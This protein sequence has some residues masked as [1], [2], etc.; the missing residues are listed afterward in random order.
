MAMGAGRLRIIRQLLVESLMLAGLGAALG[1]VLA[2]WGLDILKLIIPSDMPHLDQIGVDARV[3][4]FTL[5][6]SALTALI[7]GLVPA[8]EASHPDLNET[9]RGRQQ[10]ATGACA[11][12]GFVACWVYR[13]RSGACAARTARVCCSKF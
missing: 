7:F 6:V 9:L 12:E 4:G 11:V 10:G 8:I 5:A 13:S 3:F 1:L 2:M